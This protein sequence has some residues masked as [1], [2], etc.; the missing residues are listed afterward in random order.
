[1]KKVAFSVLK[2][3][4][5]KSTT[6]GNVAYCLSQAKKTVLV[7][8][9]PQG[10]VSS[11]FLTDAPEYELADVLIGRATVRDALVKI[12]KKFFL[13][14]TF[15]IGGRLKEYSETRLFQEPFIFVDLCDE[16]S[17]SFDYAI[18]DLCA[19]MSQLERTVLSAM[20]EVITPLSPE[21]FSLDGIEIFSN[22]L[23]KI[24][25]SFRTDVKHDKIV[26]NGLNK[27][28]MRHKHIYKKFQSMDFNMFTIPQ[29]SKLPESQLTHQSIFQY[30]PKSKSIPEIQRIAEAI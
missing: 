13:L 30:Y 1:M 29:D 8:C 7:D 9:D 19:G 17:K 5:G 14:P 3:G 18:F 2:G 27:S 15:S 12:S 10:N 22:E 11:W 25:R 21:Y 20:D 28:F 6:S 26:C 24:N 23:Q 16:L 4:T